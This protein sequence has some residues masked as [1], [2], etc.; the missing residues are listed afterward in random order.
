[1]LRASRVFFQQRF[2]LVL[3]CA[4]CVAY[5]T[6]T[7][8]ALHK[9]CNVELLGGGLRQQRKRALDGEFPGVGKTLSQTRLVGTVPATQSQLA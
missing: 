2:V 5:T 9:A 6:N 4:R 8:R 7:V 3:W 1:M